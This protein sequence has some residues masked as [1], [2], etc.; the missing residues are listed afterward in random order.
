MP[1]IN[2]VWEQALQINANLGTL[3]N[4][5]VDLKECC[6]RNTDRSSSRS[7]T[8]SCFRCCGF[9]AARA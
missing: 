6:A 4:D 8:D 5:E 9:I 3:H 2:E 7:G 1:T